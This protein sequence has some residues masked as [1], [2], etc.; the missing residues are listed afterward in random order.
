LF[1]QWKAQGIFLRTILAA[2]RAAALIESAWNAGHQASS[3][4]Q[5]GERRNAG[6]RRPHEGINRPVEA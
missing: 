1:D 3:S 5:R 4:C 6:Q 2:K